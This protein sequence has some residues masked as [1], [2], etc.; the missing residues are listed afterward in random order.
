MLNPF[1]SR[2]LLTLIFT[3]MALPCFA[4]G[5]L[6]TN[7][8]GIPF[9]W[10]KTII[11]NPE[12][13]AL[14]PG[15]IDHHASVALIEEAVATW[16]SVPGVDLEVLI[17]SKLDDGGDVNSTNYETHYQSDAWFNYDGDPHTPS[18]NPIIF[19]ADGS[20]IE[21]IFGECAQFKMLGFAGYTD[22]AG[23][24]PDPQWT[25]LKRG[26][27]IFNGACIAPAITKA[28]CPPCQTVLDLGDVKKLILHEMGH[29]LGL[30][31]SQVNPLAYQS[32][33]VNGECPEEVAHQVPT[34]F[35][36]LLK[37]SH[38]EILHRDDEV[39]MQRLY[40]N[41]QAHTCTVSGWV[42]ASH[43]QEELRGVEVVARNTQDSQALTDA[44]SYVSG[45]EAPRY[46]LKELRQ[47]NC[48]EACGDFEINGLRPGQ[49]YQLCVQRIDARFEGT[50]FIAPL[51]QPF[52]DFDEDCPAQLTFHCE[53]EGDQCDRFDGVEIQTTNNG[54]DHPNTILDSASPSPGAG[55]SGCSLAGPSPRLDLLWIMV[56]IPWALTIT[57]TRSH[58]A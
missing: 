21:N 29:F 49:S 8:D 57:R 53:C 1:L 54:L 11:L 58:R 10:D 9:S 52:Q 5:A 56:L 19:D 6:K 22:F 47:E 45:E 31:H 46:E 28:G 34:M 36:F 18:S 55:A 33:K 12:H 35:P 41:P 44:I 38:Q 43:S 37:G 26:Q 7:I 32:C 24:D 25:Q 3:L 27:A 51:N 16:S 42:L 2:S 48:V 23:D 17:G 4:G 30:G 50:R 15:V 39:A 13:G 20:I 40:G 14:K